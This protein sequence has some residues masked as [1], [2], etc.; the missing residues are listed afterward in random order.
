MVALK[1]LPIDQFGLVSFLLMTKT[2]D[3]DRV[4]LL[5]QQTIYGGGM[6]GKAD[7]LPMRQGERTV[8]CVWRRRRMRSIITKMHKNT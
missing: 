4:H 2:K 6:Q 7:G 8:S 5:C 3:N 1:A